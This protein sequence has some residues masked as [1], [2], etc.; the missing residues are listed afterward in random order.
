LINLF[1]DGGSQ[2]DGTFYFEENLRSGV[3]NYLFGHVI[4][5][6]DEEGHFWYNNKTLIIIYMV[7][8]QTESKTI[9]P[10]LIE[11]MQKGAGYEELLQMWAQLSEQLDF[12]SGSS[13]LY[14]VLDT[15]HQS[16][17]Q[18][19]CDSSVKEI[20]ATPAYLEELQRL[21][22][23]KE[24]LLQCVMVG[25]LVSQ[26]DILKSGN[27]K[28]GKIEPQTLWL[29][30]NGWDWANTKLR[31]IKQQADKEQASRAEE[32][33]IEET[34]Q[35]VKKDTLIAELKANLENPKFK[36][37]QQQNDLIRY[38]FRDKL[39]KWKAFCDKNM[40]EKEIK[41]LR[42]GEQG[43]KKITQDIYVKFIEICKRIPRI[44]EKDIPFEIINPNSGWFY[45]L[46]KN[47]A[48]SINGF[49]QKA[50]SN[51]F[52]WFQL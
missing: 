52:D 38:D 3:G 26:L 13:Q 12:K 18:G 29:E 47:N 1:T 22:I 31:E 11:K 27:Y 23:P 49:L 8:K 17:K 28:T 51:M 40:S 21:S 33:N 32:S 2:G 6:I 44:K 45:V 9:S 25:A 37:T 20:F 10:D 46:V 42:L 34:V 48:N 7:E 16:L 5:T 19:A 35:N 43:D 50:V 39:I 24:F 15:V 30:T 4:T 41:E 36:M 14:K